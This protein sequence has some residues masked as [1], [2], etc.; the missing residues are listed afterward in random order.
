M[1]WV[2]YKGGVGFISPIMRPQLTLHNVSST[3]FKPNSHYT[4]LE[5]YLNPTHL[6]NVRSVFKP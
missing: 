3:V 5:V 2:E 1:G 4:M 6:H